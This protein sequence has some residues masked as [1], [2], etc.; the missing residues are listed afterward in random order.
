MG[1]S[2]RYPLVANNEVIVNLP[3]L[4]W[5]TTWLSALCII[6]RTERKIHLKFT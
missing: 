3:I 4:T 5:N 2:Y 1:N 6:K